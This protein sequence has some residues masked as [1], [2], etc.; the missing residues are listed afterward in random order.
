[1]GERGG[2]RGEYCK[3]WLCP[4]L[5]TLWLHQSFS[6]PLSFPLTFTFLIHFICHCLISSPSAS[7]STFRALPTS[8]AAN[9]WE[10]NFTIQERFVSKS[11]SFSKCCLYSSTCISLTYLNIM[12]LTV[13]LKYVT[14]AMILAYTVFITK[15]A[16]LFA[17]KEQLHL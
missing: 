14:T 5:R 10:I 7:I 2:K 13:R 3:I 16:K 9:K 17:L 6:F 4:F 12:E 11:A 8:A 15:R 1:M